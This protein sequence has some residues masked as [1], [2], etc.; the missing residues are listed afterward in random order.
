M[1]MTSTTP[2]P[3]APAQMPSRPVPRWARVLNLCLVA[4]GVVALVVALNYFA[5]SGALRHR[6]DATKTRAYTLSEQ[7][8]RMLAGL[9]GRWRIAVIASQRRLDRA[10][11]RQIDEVLDRYAAAAPGLEIVRIDPEDPQTLM[12]YDQLLAEIEA[13]YAQPR[14]EF[15]QAIDAGLRAYAAL[16]VFAQQHSSKLDQAASKIPE[17]NPARAQI[18]PRVA[19]LAMLADQGGLVSA[20][21]HKA[22]KVDDAKPIPDYE[23]ARSILAQALGQWS[24]EL[25]DMAAILSQW[26]QQANLDLEARRYAST[27][28][29]EYQQQSQS[30]AVAADPL[31]RLPP[32]ELS[33]IGTQLQQGE[34]A[35]ILSPD[36][37]A[38]IPSALLFPKS[39]IQRREDGAVRFDQRFRGE[40]LISAAIQSLTV[41]HMPRV[42]FVHAEDGSIL[43]SRENHQDLV[44]LTETLR[45]SGYAVEE[46]SLTQGLPR[47]QS[48]ATAQATVWV[49][50][51]PPPARS[52]D[53]AGPMR[54]VVDALAQLVRDGE[55]I[56]LNLHPSLMARFG[57]RD[58]LVAAVG[59][60]GLAADTA[61][62]LFER[63]SSPAP[64]AAISRDQALIDFH[65]QHPIA[66]ALNGQRLYLTLPVRL[67][68]SGSPP[69]GVQLFP[70]A[71]VRANGNRW[72]EHDW[73]RASTDPPP[74]T[75]VE[76][77]S[78]P[79]PVIYAAERTRIEHGRPQRLLLVGSGGWMITNVANRAANI[80]GDRVTL[81][82]PGNHELMLAGAAW[83]AGMDD[84]IAASPLS[85][86]VER[87]QGLT[88]AARNAWFWAVTA[89]LP[90]ACLVF[91][92]IV[93][94]MRRR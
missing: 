45:A 89:A 63:P 52:I 29:G 93:F 90:A 72:L 33:T 94:I 88:P 44:G 14:A 32:L 7:T 37:A 62:I 24:G 58:P 16:Q 8:T 27:A 53:A 66:R 71:H 31:K 41:Q 68:P 39:N 78:E 21:V 79:V 47:P 17:D 64:S 23:T 11:R 87:I 5:A 13:A 65:E 91:G 59:E 6:V 84:L 69:P 12:A 40:Q 51:P 46:W 15:T 82:N 73:V 76:S 75:G 9:S 30:L 86:Q 54:S 80:G 49:I 83:L 57:Q 61:R 77:I 36:R 20:E 85:Q 35:V 22:L 81:E 2:R 60:L 25:D 28:R 3:Y 38:V 34:C 48:N 74:A 67:E 92:T 42:V 55:S 10:M 50:V 18:Q 4:A 70:I 43:K 26:A 56:L 19:V 1:A